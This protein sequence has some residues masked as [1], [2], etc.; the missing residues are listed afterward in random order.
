MKRS[1]AAWLLLA[2]FPACTAVPEPSP[3]AAAEASW[4][5]LFDAGCVAPW[6]ATDFGGQGDV[7]VLDGRLELGMGNPLTG[8]T[9]TENVPHGDYELE[10][11]ARRDAG[12]DFFC[13][14]TFP[15]GEQ[16]LTLVLG[17][18]GGTLCGLSCLDG[19]DASR[20]ETRTLRRLGRGVDH[21][22]VVRVAAGRVVVTLDGEPLCAVDTRGRT[23]DL[24]QEVLLSRPL[25]VASFAT[26]ASLARLRW[27]SLP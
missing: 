6:V 12:N 20:N 19:K 23:L 9:W 21:D 5:V 26:T 2:T 24:R 27:R 18:W 10:L 16:H 25:G 17:G 22:V 4:Q 13:G 3:P 7:R 8:V 14:L 1:A 11:T 15:V